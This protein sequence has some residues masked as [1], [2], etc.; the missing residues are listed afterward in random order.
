VSG[1]VARRDWATWGCG[2]SER[3]IANYG[4]AS[5]CKRGCA[6]VQSRQQSLRTNDGQQSLRTGDGGEELGGSEARP[7]V[8]SFRGF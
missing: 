1:P 6:I 8:A 2:L 5:R 3:A 7:R 4:A